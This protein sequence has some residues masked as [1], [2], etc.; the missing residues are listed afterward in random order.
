MPNR[1]RAQTRLHALCT[2]AGLNGLREESVLLALGDADGSVRRH[3][4]RVSEPLI[5]SIRELARCIAALA[6]DP[7]PQVKLQLAYT[8]G[9]WS[10]SSVCATLAEMAW[11]DHAD[12][13][14]VAAVLSSVNRKNAA[15]FVEQLLSRTDDRELPP[16][17]RDA[18]ISVSAKLGGDSCVRETLSALTRT[19]G[20]NF[21]TERLDTLARFLERA[22]CKS[23]ALLLRSEIGA[24]AANHL[25]SAARQALQD[26]GDDEQR[27]LAAIRI[28]AIAAPSG[29]DLT[30]EVGEL[31]G[32]R[33]SPAVQEAAVE[34]LARASGSQTGEILL[35]N[36]AGYSPTLRGQVLDVLLGR[37]DL[38]PHLLEG[39]TAGDV[40]LAHLDASQRQRMLTHAKPEIRAAATAAF[41]GAIDANRAKIIES[42]AE[43]ARLPGDAA[44]GR[45]L[46]R[47][48]CSSCHRLEDDGHAVGPDLAALTTRTT[49]APLEALFDP[50]RTADERDQSY[51]AITDEGRTYTGILKAE[52]STSITLVEQQ[53]QE[54]TLLRN[55]LDELASSGI[56]YMP[57]G[58]EKDL[59]VED[60]ADLFAYMGTQGTTS[61]TSSASPDTP[62]GSV[63]RL[64][65]EGERTLG[66]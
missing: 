37:D 44:K 35:E 28:L 49:P 19:G 56:S 51:L 33:S 8:L 45:N 46:F 30:R 34:L 13:Y 31:L 60:V 57:E 10:D 23:T 59:S 1:R 32:P 27:F 40:K 54:H 5:A 26:S 24:A 62:P 47:K 36:W 39:I 2:L 15:D 48:H 38:V 50:N 17:V 52:T 55:T 14:L 4:I 21:S 6:D 64:H 29:A 53:G 16:P 20:D 43:V 65:A 41:A 3:A 7:D 9:T 66:E 12:P 22:R 58:F 63:Q 42:Y 61:P 11:K 18:V 25:A